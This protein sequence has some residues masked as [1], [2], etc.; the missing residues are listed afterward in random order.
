VVGLIHDIPTCKV[1]VERIEKEA[2][3]SLS[4]AQSL[5][6]DEQ[7]PA[8]VSGKPASAIQAKL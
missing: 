8:D 1:L 5:V 2:I 6:V 4:K 7:P 3:E